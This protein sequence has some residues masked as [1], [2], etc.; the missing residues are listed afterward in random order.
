M[1]GVARWAAFLRMLV[2]LETAASIFSGV[3]SFYS[4][5]LGCLSQ[6]CI[7]ANQ[8]AGCGVWALVFCNEYSAEGG[9]DRGMVR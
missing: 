5:L 9:Y 1:A 6:I 3:L 7:C 4:P 8:Y 2:N